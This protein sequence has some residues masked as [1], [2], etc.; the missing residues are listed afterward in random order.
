MLLLLFIMCIIIINLYPVYHKVND[1]VIENTNYPKIEIKDNIA[2]I[3]DHSYGLRIYDVSEPAEPVL[4]N[5]LPL[6]YD[7]RCILLDQPTAYLLCNY[8]N[9]MYILDTQDITN[10]VVLSQYTTTYPCRDVSVNT[11][12]AFISTHNELNI[13]PWE[14]DFIEIINIED[15]LNPVYVD[16]FVIAS[17]SPTVKITDDIAFIGTYLGLYIYDISDISNIVQ[18]DWLDTGNTFALKIHNGLLYFDGRDGL[19]IMDY[20]DPSNCQIL[21]FYDDLD[22]QDS[23]IIGNILYASF[24]SF[25]RVIDISDPLNA[26]QIHY[27]ISIEESNSIAVKDNY[28]YINNWYYSFNII[29]V[30]NSQNPYLYDYHDIRAEKIAKSPDDMFM[31]VYGSPYDGLHF[32]NMEDS[33]NPELVYSHISHGNDWS[34]SSFYIDD[35]ICCSVFGDIDEKEFNIYDLT[36]L[37]NAPLFSTTEISY[38]TFYFWIESICRKDNFM[39]L[40][41][42]GDGI[43]IMDISN[44]QNPVQVLNYDIEGFIFDITVQGN[45]LYYVNI[46]GFYVLDITDP[47]Q[48]VQVGFWDSTNRAEQFE[49]YGDFA[50]VVDYDG[51]IKVLDISDPANP[52]LINTVALNTTSRIDYD[53]IIRDNKLIITDRHWNEIMVFDLSNPVNPVLIYNCRWDK[54]TNDM[55]LFGDYLY[56]A[57]SSDVF[58]VYGLSVLD[59]YLFNPVH[60]ENPAIEPASGILKLTNYPNPFNPTTTIEF[61]ISNESD[62]EIS[63]YNIKGQ[64]IKALTNNVVIAGTHSIIW[65]GDN[66]NNEPVSSGIYFYKLIVN[67]KI[68]SVKKCLLL[69]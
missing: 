11:N 8:D 50:Y 10:P 42:P 53:P 27:Y 7:V 31:L 28:A 51:G 34:C 49:L 56:C 18:I 67:G 40:T 17:Y 59:F 39:Y 52:S 62:I 54:Y 68:E 26:Y 36:R 25:L 20:S 14:E 37:Q 43:I 38:N 57:N 46:D 45:F 19:T 24:N 5:S 15:R 30:S 63:I 9:T 2:Y 60:S 64:K 48:P 32:F 29:D 44:L 12:Y 69:K 65:S 6:Q 41:C 16:E 3:A 23:E 55:E 61:S 33:A 21:A 66:E 4:I 47:L 13:P 35:Q 22:F 1:L 58:D